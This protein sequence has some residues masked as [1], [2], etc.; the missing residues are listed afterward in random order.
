MQRRQRIGVKS[1]FQTLEME[2]PLQKKQ[3]YCTP[4]EEQCI[5]T[6][7]KEPQQ[8]PTDDQEDYINTKQK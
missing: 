1:L 3:R 8:R 6:N 5:I 7:K 4:P 2:P